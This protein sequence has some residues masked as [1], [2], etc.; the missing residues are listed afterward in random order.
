[1][2]KYMGCRK[3]EYKPLVTSPDAFGV[4]EKDFPK[5]MRDSTTSEKLTTASTRPAI[6]AA[7]IS[8]TLHT[9]R[10]PKNDFQSNLTGGAFAWLDKREIRA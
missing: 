9:D 8:I 4:T 7:F 5:W 2:N 10:F 6:L 3:R 1:M